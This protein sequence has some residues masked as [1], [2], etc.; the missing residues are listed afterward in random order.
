MLQRCYVLKL[1]L[2]CVV[3]LLFGFCSA[4][5][6]ERRVLKYTMY[7][8]AIG[9]T[10]DGTLDPLRTLQ[11]LYYTLQ[12]Q[13]FETLVAID[14]NTQRIIPVLAERWDRKDAL[15]TRFFLR[16]GVRFH[17]GE[18]FTAEA[19]KFTLELMRDP[20][21]KFGGRFLF[22][23]IAAVQVIDDY[24]VDII[25]LSPDALLLRKLAAFGFIFPPKYY[26][27]VGDKYFTRY[28]MGTGPFRFFYNAKNE[29]GIK[30][31]H[32]VANEDYWGKAPAS[33]HELVYEFIPREGKSQALKNGAI[34]L[35]ITQDTS[36]AKDLRGEPDIKITAQQ[37]LRSAVCL[38]NTDKAG[39]LADIR[40]R[41]A[42]QHAINRNDIIATALNG[43]GKPLFT[44]APAGSIAFTGGKPMY[45]EN[46]SAA[47]ELLKQAGHPQGISLK[48]MAAN[49]NPTIAV[50][51][52][53]RRQLAAN[54]V[55]LDVHLLTREEIKKEI[56]EPKLKGEVKP[57]GY[58]MWVVNGWP[59]IFGAA[60][61]FYF[62]FLHSRG[63]FNLGI[64][65]SGDSPVNARY[66]EALA[67]TDGNT[68]ADRL[69]QLDLA[70]MEQALVI[71]LCQIE[72]VYAM[73]KKVHFNPGLNDLPLR[74]TECS[75]K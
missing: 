33:L 5:A 46:P 19:V 72:L 4:G 59:D 34:D 20:R 64:N 42:L 16:R 11:M 25:L 17:N 37:S 61:H 28:P 63:I 40:V 13:M 48:V 60:A 36:L 44:A 43:Y 55:I 3:L 53:L 62:V 68:L 7:E 57:S 66:A 9:T 2:L 58:D 8:A 39:P 49:N 70:V 1:S 51:D 54:G 71:P 14:F 10:D 12:H 41:R 30:E 35:L 6:G 24:T 26:S 69:R 31:I 38:L 27:R 18:L 67:A 50:V 73:H 29:A 52:V 22:E 75:I 45:D 23:S 56:V 21:N 32:F 15:T 74:F 47:K 65:L